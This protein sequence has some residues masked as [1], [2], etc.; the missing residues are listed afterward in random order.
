MSSKKRRAVF[1]LHIRLRDI[2][3]AIWRRIQIWEDA[4]LPQLHRILQMLFNWEDYHLHDFLAGPRVYSVPD[5]EDDFNERK[6][7]DE[8]GVPLNR[9]VDRAGDTFVCTYDF[10]DDP[11]RVGVDRT[12]RRRHPFPWR[13]PHACGADRCQ[14]H[15]AIKV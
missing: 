7:I 6:V 15:A 10:G 4:K 8:R 12:R 1:Q 11:T 3:P 9:I 2:E 5:P 14:Y 13:F